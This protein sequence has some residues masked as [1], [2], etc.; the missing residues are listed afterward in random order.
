M[1][2]SRVKSQG[3]SRGSSAPDPTRLVGSPAL[4]R[5][6]EQLA[7]AH[8][9]T[10]PQHE[11]FAVDRLGQE[12][13]GAEDQGAVARDVA[14]VVGQHEHR[15][16][17]RLERAPLSRRK[18]SKPSGSGMWRSRMTTSGSNSAKTSSIWRESARAQTSSTESSR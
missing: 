16:E 13:V 6:D 8:Q 3:A 4:A 7:R 11:L 17:T 5:L 2:P 1:P 15:Q 10:N 18:T 14:F 12:F 9:V